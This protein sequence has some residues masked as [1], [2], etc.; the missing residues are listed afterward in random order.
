MRSGHENVYKKTFYSVTN[1]FIILFIT[2]NKYYTICSY[3]ITVHRIIGNKITLMYDIHSCENVY[4]NC[5]INFSLK[6]L[7]V[8]HKKN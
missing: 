6:L 7:S 5:T 1:I 3:S 8:G 4:E 2:Y